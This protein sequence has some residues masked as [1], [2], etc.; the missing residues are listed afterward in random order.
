LTVRNYSNNAVDTTLVGS[1]DNAVTAMV[2][3]SVSG[4]PTSYPYSL[5]INHA[6]ANEEVVTVTNAVATTLTIVRGEDGTAAASH[7]SGATVKHVITARD[8]AEPQSHMDASTNVHGLSGGAAVV[9]TSQAQTLTNK[10]ISGASNTLTNIPAANVTGTFASVNASGNIDSGGNIT[11]L[12]GN[13]FSAAVGFD[14]TIGGD[15]DVSG[16]GPYFRDVDVQTFTA[17]DT[18]DKPANAKW[19]RVVAVGGG[20]GGGG[21]ANTGVNETAW[22]GGGGGGGT[23]E[24]WFDADSLGAT[25]AVTVGAG[26]AGGAAGNNPGSAGGSSTFDSLSAAGGGGGTGMAT[27][28]TSAQSAGG[29][30][31]GATGAHFEIFGGDGGNGTRASGS[32][33]GTQGYGGSSHFVGT[34]RCSTST[35]GAAG[36]SSGGFGGGGSGAHNFASQGLGKAGGDGGAGIVVVYTFT[37]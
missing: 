35:T 25:E 12:T 31:G 37:G 24:K 29:D 4:F 28:S 5:A 33:F 36:V 22:S 16:A 14:V 34:L 13:F 21:V 2:V 3:G 15:L 1:I 23:G 7:T 20:G 8:L 9:G 30:G 11:G 19:V 32:S 17:D 6:E 10:T 27:G 26:G 18:W